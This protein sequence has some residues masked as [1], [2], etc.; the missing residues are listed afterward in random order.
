MPG[1]EVLYKPHLGCIKRRDKLFDPFRGYG[2][3]FLFIVQGFA[4]WV[5]KGPA[6]Y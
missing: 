1:S 2:V 5:K 6:Q 4:S 3:F